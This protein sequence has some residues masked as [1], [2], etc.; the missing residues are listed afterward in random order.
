[1]NIQARFSLSTAYKALGRYD[2]AIRVLRE[3]IRY[4]PTHQAYSNLGSTLLRLR[5]FTEAAIELEQARNLNPRAFTQIGNL[6]RAYYFIPSKREQ[7]F[8][9]YAEAVQLA[10]QQLAKVNQRDPDVHI[11]LAWYNAMLGHAAESYRHLDQALQGQPPPEFFWIA[12][13][14]HNQFSERDRSLSF[15]EKAASEGFSKFEIQ[16]TA[17]FDNLRDDPRFR[18]VIAQP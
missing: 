18:K 4:R 13:I 9:F 8:A 17:E 3:S 7:S 11:M 5:R 14:V 16:N 12:A 10:D 1:M 6:A 2:D 15:L